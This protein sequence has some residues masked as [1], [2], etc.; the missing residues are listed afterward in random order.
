MP[1]S[2]K[3]YERTAEAIRLH[4]NAVSHD[5]VFDNGV[6]YAAR[7]ISYELAKFFAE[8]NANFDQRKFILAC[9]LDNS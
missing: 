2:R 7:N 4:G 9:G 1:L 8:D 3:H 6:N 5:Q